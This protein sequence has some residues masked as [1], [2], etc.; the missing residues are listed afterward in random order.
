[1]LLPFTGRSLIYLLLRFHFSYV[2][3]YELRVKFDN[4]L[5]FLSISPSNRR[6]P[7]NR[8]SVSNQIILHVQPLSP[9]SSSTFFVAAHAFSRYVS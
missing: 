3:T 1:M 4:M 7:F 6:S 8:A 9:A 5:I 2:L